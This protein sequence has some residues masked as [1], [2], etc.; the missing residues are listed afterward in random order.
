MFE[1]ACVIIHL[2]ILILCFTFQQQK[3]AYRFCN[4]HNVGVANGLWVTNRDLK[5]SKTSGGNISLPSVLTFYDHYYG[6][7]A[8][9]GVA[10]AR[11]LT[12][13]G[14]VVET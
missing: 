2:L 9:M 1:F 6:S 3:I 5:P 13:S 4:F 8:K 11:H 14:D 12:L 7:F 10:R